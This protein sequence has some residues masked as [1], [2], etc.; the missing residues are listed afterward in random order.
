MQTQKLDAGSRDAVAAD[1]EFDQCLRYLGITP[2]S[3]SVA[4]CG[5]C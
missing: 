3:Y 5:Y 2:S 4:R 1:I